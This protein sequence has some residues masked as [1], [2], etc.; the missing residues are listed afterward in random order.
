MRHFAAVLLACLLFAVPAAAKGPLPEPD[1]GPD[2]R[3]LTVTGSGV[4]L[5]KPPQRLTK[6]RIERAV[7]A[8]KP[9]AMRRAIGAA[10]L[11]AAALASA[12]GVTLGD[13]VAVNE[14][15]GQAE[16]GYVNQRPICSG[17]RCR[18]PAL[19]SASVTVTFATAQTSAATPSGQALVASGV[20]EANVRPR[21]RRNSASIRAA[22]ARAQAAAA[23][24]ALREAQA[25]AASLAAGL[26]R[27]LGALFAI[28]EIRR[29]Q[30]DFS[31]MLGSFGPGVYCGEVRRTIFRRDSTGRRR[32]VRRVTERRCWYPFQI[33]VAL[34]V[35]Y[36]PA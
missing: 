7:A 12:A 11:R 22:I 17:R 19:A 3:G 28:A 30:Q 35:T 24:E 36:L 25:D 33:D 20:G 16:L 5:V 34:R 9:A 15:D 32:P 2:P 26:G 18:A 21:N 1:D 23:P 8:A 14:R 10:R 6:A 4:A 27:P 13:A 31:W 29:P